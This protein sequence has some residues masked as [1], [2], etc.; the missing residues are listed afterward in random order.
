MPAKPIPTGPAAAMYAEG[1]PQGFDEMAEQLFAPSSDITTMRLQ[2]IE[3]RLNEICDVLHRA[4]VS[5]VFMPINTM[6]RQRVI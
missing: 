6:H 4:G 2:I 3:A 5:P 1:K